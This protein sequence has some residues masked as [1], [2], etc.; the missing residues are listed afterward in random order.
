MYSGYSFYKWPQIN[1]ILLK[2]FLVLQDINIYSKTIY[3]A[4][5]YHD[6]NWKETIVQL[7]L[8]E[9]PWVFVHFYNLTKFNFHSFDE[10]Y[11]FFISESYFWSLMNLFQ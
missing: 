4:P 6:G 5:Y 1:L 11:L 7:L 3:M 9:L 10:S 2:H 8:D